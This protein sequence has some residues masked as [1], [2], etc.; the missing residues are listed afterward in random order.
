MCVLLI[1]RVEQA[2]SRVHS[3]FWYRV[4]ETRPG[5]KRDRHGLLVQLFWGEDREQSRPWSHFRSLFYIGFGDSFEDRRRDSKPWDEFKVLSIWVFRV[6]LGRGTEKRE[7]EPW[8]LLNVL[9][10]TSIQNSFWQREKTVH[11][12]YRCPFLIWIS[13]TLM[14]KDRGRRERAHTMRWS[15]SISDMWGPWP[16]LEETRERKRREQTMQCSCC[17]FWY[18]HLWLFWAEREEREQNMRCIWRD[19]WSE[20]PGIFWADKERRE[21]RAY[22][23]FL[24][25]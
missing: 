13:T 9:F 23:D 19:F 21:S 10:D 22:A 16:I 7:G 14:K 11:P 17:P 20:D 2:M 24:Y 6:V 12:A 3:A 18:M 8:H 4:F 5:R 1:E 25:L 15:R